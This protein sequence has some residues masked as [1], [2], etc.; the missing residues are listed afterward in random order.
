MEEG[1]RKAL[2]EG[3][4]RHA[5]SASDLSRELGL[6][7]S[8]FVDLLAGRKKS[9]T[10][11]AYLLA[12][13]RIGFDPWE[14]AGIEAPSSGASR[15]APAVVPIPSPAPVPA[16]PHRLAV[17]GI[18]EESAYRQDGGVMGKR[19]H[20]VI[21]GYPVDRQSMAIVRGTDYI[22]WGVPDGAVLGLVSYR[23]YETVAGPGRLVVIGVSR[24][25][26][27]GVNLRRAVMDGDGEPML[28]APDGK[29]EPLALPDTAS[30]VGLVVRIGIPP[31]SD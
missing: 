3:L 28:E 13:R 22:L 9:V 19:E 10:A 6:D 27:R 18:V 2:R 11:E 12:S 14:V 26:L 31:P 23:R 7:K 8:Y 24:D 20:A 25:G 29:R 30:I 5:I 21:E 16:P 17:T 15:T 1:F 4:E